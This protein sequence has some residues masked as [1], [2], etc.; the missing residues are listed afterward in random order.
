MNLTNKQYLAIGMAILAF[1][2]ASSGQMTE[3]LG[4]EIAKGIASGSAF[5]N[6]I[7]AAV[8]A[9]IT[10]Q[11]SLVKDVQAMP[12]V[13]K[14]EVNSQANQ[15]LASM[16][17]DPSEDKITVTRGDEQVVANSAAS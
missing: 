14:I 9:A 10:G 12:G 1:L 8:L 13:Q 2:S 3:F 17:V 4:P 6:G 15:T 11:S 7:L 5:I 16:A